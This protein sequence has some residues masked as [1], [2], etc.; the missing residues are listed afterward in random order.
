MYSYAR[1]KR[2][3]L[4]ASAKNSRVECGQQLINWLKKKPSSTILVFSDKKHWTVDQSRNAR[5]DRVVVTDGKRM[6]PYWFPKGLRLGTKEYLEVMRGIVKPW[7][8][9]TY[10]DGKDTKLK[11]CNSGVR[12]I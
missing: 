9:A 4:S 7:M 1:R 2:Q 6:P 5:N 10:P 8:D 11:L 3:L 12:R